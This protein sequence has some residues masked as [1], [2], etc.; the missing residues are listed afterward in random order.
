MLGAAIEL[1]DYMEGDNRNFLKIL[2]ECLR[3]WELIY[4]CGSIRDAEIMLKKDV[5]KLRRRFEVSLKKLQRLSQFVNEDGTK[6]TNKEFMY[7][8]EAFD[9]LGDVQGK[10]T[11][12]HTQTCRDIL[13][14]LENCHSLVD[15]RLPFKK[16]DYV[17]DLKRSNLKQAL[18]LH[19]RVSSK[20][21][22]FPDEEKEEK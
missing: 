8:F 5:T 13:K 1:T 9:P 4:N 10:N 15:R 22:N 2:N 16:D 21:Q 12:P 7:Q 6:E 19:W 20:N 14:C 11:I 18:F 17:N 3:A